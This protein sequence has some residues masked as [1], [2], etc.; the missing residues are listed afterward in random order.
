MLVRVREKGTLI[1]CWWECK[2]VQP[3][4][5]TIWSF[6]KKLNIDL[7]YDLI[8][9]LFGIYLK[10]CNSSYYKA[11]AHPGLLQHYSQ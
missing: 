5:K 2:I 6:L 1:H 11:P 10:E 4:W 8:I 3:F 7:L 9:P